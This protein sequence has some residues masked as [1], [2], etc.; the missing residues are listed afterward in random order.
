MTYA[1]KQRIAALRASGDSYAGIAAALGMSE[2]TIQSHCRRH[3]LGSNAMKGGG[4]TGIG[5]AHCGK[6][7][8]KRRQK[9]KRFCSDKCRMAWWKE[10]PE[11]LNRKAVYHFTCAYCGT[12]FGSYGN[13]HRKYCSRA[14]YSRAKTRVVRPVEEGT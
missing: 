13:N 4:N 1:Q 12:S 10:H 8:G 7:L 5:C 2:N 11:E 3:G 14:C 6:L 9:N